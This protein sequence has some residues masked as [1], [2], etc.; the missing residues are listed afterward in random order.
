[1]ENK[2]KKKKQNNILLDIKYESCLCNCLLFNKSLKKSVF[3]S[4]HL[5]FVSNDLKTHGSFFK[6]LFHTFNLTRLGVKFLN[7]IYSSV[8]GVPLL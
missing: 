6:S 3:N 2:S 7:G 1:M 5:Y 4:S 8:T